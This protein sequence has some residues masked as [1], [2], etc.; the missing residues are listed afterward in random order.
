MGPMGN[1]EMELLNITFEGPVSSSIRS[2]TPSCDLKSGR[3]LLF[4]EKK[5]LV[6]YINC[7]GEL[8]FLRIQCVH[9]RM[10]YG[11]VCYNAVSVENDFV[12]VLLIQPLKYS[13]EKYLKI[14]C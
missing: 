13:N 11:F 3:K 10:S 5:R 6:P 12:R 4:V 14:C 1:E 9:K 8:Y 7:T 2:Q